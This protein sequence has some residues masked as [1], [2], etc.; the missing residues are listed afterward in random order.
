MLALVS[1]FCWE[2]HSKQ[3]RH[4]AAPAKRLHIRLLSI[5]FLSKFDNTYAPVLYIL[6]VFFCHIWSYFCHTQHNVFFSTLFSRF[7]QVNL[8]RFVQQNIL[9]LNAIHFHLERGFHKFQQYFDEISFEKSMSRDF[10]NRDTTQSDTD[11]IYPR[12][13]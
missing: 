6:V 2:V 13:G 11:V 4:P 12:D 5:V 1:I 10:R 8:I 7:V 9:K 3:N